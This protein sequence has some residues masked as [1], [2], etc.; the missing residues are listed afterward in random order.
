M[1]TQCAAKAILRRHLCG[2]SAHHDSLF[3]LEGDGMAMQFNL[4]WWK[5]RRKNQINRAAR[6]LP[7][8]FGCVYVGVKILGL[9]LPSFTIRDTFLEPHQNTDQLNTYY[10][11]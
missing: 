10:Y 4:E 5:Q 1:P 8:F 6:V 9:L 7:L 2:F 3:S 11:Y